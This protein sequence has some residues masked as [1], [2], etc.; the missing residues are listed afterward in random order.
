MAVSQQIPSKAP[1]RNFGAD[2]FQDAPQGR[3][4]EEGER[5][6]I[7]FPKPMD[8]KTEDSKKKRITIC[9]YHPHCSEYGILALEKHG[10]FKGWIKIMNR[11][12]K[13]NKYQHLESCIDYP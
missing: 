6:K 9:S 11:V 10:F 12:K 2:P 8:G 1:N 13:C 5:E 4:N 3:E 7:P